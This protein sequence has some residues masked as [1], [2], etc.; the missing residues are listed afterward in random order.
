MAAKNGCGRVPDSAGA[1]LTKIE[2][3][4]AG[5]LKCISGAWMFRET[6]K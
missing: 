3:L 2:L 4:R 1:I 6:I 5:F